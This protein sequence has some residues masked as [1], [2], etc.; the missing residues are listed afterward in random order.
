MDGSGINWQAHS[1]NVGEPVWVQSDNVAWER[2]HL[3]TIADREISVE[4]SK[5]SKL[6]RISLDRKGRTVRQHVLPRISTQSASR[7]A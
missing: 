1:Q 3:R 5:T 7:K 4:I 2:G 6:V